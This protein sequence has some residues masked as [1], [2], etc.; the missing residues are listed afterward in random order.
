MPVTARRVPAGVP[1]GAAVG[2]SRAVRSGPLV[3]VSG[4]T[5]V[6]D[7]VPV[8]GDDT[9]AQAVEAVRT[10]VDAL[11]QLGASPADVVQTRIY[12]TDADEWDRVAPAHRAA[13]GAHPPATTLV[14]VPRLID[15]RMRVEIEAVAWV[16]GRARQPAAGSRE[17]GDG[18]ADYAVSRPAPSGPPPR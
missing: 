8:G 12:V 1:W 16:A 11:A 3:A 10:V 6:R 7:G 17:P 14:E 13:F 4:T 2:Y 18:S 9:G 5:A 15:P